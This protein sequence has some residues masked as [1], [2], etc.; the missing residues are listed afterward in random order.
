MLG[1]ASMAPEDHS[2]TQKLYGLA[3]V[4]LE[5]DLISL[6]FPFDA[7]IASHMLASWLWRQGRMI[8]AHLMNGKALQWAAPQSITDGSRLAIACGLH[9]IPSS[10]WLESAMF[11]EEPTGMPAVLGPAI[12]TIELC[13]RIHV[14]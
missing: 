10:T 14:L 13:E 6:R 8:E 7:V 3:K 12:D 11:V 5:E 9:C 1:S 2:R 4:A